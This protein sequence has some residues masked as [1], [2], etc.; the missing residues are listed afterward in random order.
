[1]KKKYF[2]PE[3]E[4]MEI[5]NTVLLVT[6]GCSDESETGSEQAGEDPVTDFG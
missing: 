5:E 3:M 4:E 6:S 2:S 1:M